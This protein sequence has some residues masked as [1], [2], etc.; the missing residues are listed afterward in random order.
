MDEETFF[1]RLVDRAA[2]VGLGYLDYRVAD[3]EAE[4]ARAL[5]YQQNAG[6]ARVDSMSRYGLN[7]TS[8]TTGLPNWVL[9]AAV[10]GLGGAIIYR[11]AR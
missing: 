10:I 4:A 6:A 9:P 7:G 11:Y 3:S 1:D 8:P 2:E 5:Q